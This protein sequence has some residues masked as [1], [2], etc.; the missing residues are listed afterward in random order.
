[1]CPIKNRKIKRRSKYQ[2]Y[3]R[4][5]NI[6][7]L[8]RS[9]FFLFLVGIWCWGINKVYWFVNRSDYFKVSD[10]LLTPTTNCPDQEIIQAAQ[11][12]IGS[13]IF[14]FSKKDVEEKLKEYF[15]V[16]KKIKIKRFLPNKVKLEIEERQPIAKI[17]VGTN[18]QGVDKDGNFFPLKDVNNLPEISGVEQKEE[19]LK[20]IAFVEAVLMQENKWYNKIVKLM[21]DATYQDLVFFLPEGIKIAWGKVN[22][23][24]RDWQKE[25]DYLAAVM[26]D[27]LQKQSKIKYINLRYWNEGRGQ[28]IVRTENAKR[29]SD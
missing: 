9:I 6:F 5:R 16:I 3:R 4:E 1:M 2:A 26:N 19:Q 15:P 28:I 23:E 27:L 12:K 14:D 17:K 8:K 10:I 21:W 24:N 20:I 25:F 11:I 13:R 29:L 18:W 22:L 7:W